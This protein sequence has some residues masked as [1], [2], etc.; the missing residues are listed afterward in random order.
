MILGLVSIYAYFSNKPAINPFEHNLSTNKIT[1]RQY[2][3]QF[4]KG[5]SHGIPTLRSVF[6]GKKT[7][8]FDKD[9]KMRQKLLKN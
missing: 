8:P 9:M 6:S 4:S 5:L 2:C 3:Y 1:D 7:I